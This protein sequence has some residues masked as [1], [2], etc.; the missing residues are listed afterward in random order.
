MHRRLTGG[1]RGYGRLLVPLLQRAQG[2]VPVRHPILLRDSSDLVWRR[3]G[4]RNTGRPG[5]HGLHLVPLLL[6]VKAKMVP[7]QIW[8]R[9]HQVQWSI[10][11]LRGAFPSETPPVRFRIS[12]LRRAGGANASPGTVS[13]RKTRIVYDRAAL[14]H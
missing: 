14:R 3:P 2:Q 9:D 11:F 5:Q 12:L 4:S 6:A 1:Y 7:C 13:M 8:T 10:N